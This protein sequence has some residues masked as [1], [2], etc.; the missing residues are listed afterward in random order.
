MG[1]IKDIV[2]DVYAL[3][4]AMRPPKPDV[5]WDEVD[6]ALRPFTYVWIKTGELAPGLGAYEFP[7]LG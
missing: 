4:P 2:E 5:I 7:E 6:E 3:I 1:I